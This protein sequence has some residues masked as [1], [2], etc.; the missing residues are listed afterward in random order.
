MEGLLPNSSI[1]E[2]Q[3]AFTDKQGFPMPSS[4]SGQRVVGLEG[5]GKFVRTPVPLSNGITI[6]TYHLVR[7]EG[8]QRNEYFAI[9]HPNNP[10]IVI[11]EKQSTKNENNEYNWGKWR[12][13]AETP[14]L[15][16]CISAKASPLTPKQ[17]QYWKAAGGASGLNTQVPVNNRMFSILPFLRNTGLSFR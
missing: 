14:D 17:E 10:T 15:T 9:V 8:F 1:K 5:M 7:T 11:G 2:A 16:G 13:L 3:E 6:F 4:R 12:M